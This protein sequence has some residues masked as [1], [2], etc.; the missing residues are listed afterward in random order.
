MLIWSHRTSGKK[1]S[2]LSTYCRMLNY[3]FYLISCRLKESV[4]IHSSRRIC[5]RFRLGRRR[6][7]RRR[8]CRFQYVTIQYIAVRL[9][10]VRPHSSPIPAA[11]PTGAHTAPAA[12]AT[13]AVEATAA[14]EATLVR[15]NSTDGFNAVRNSHR[16]VPQYKQ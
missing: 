7:I 10:M 8:R 6:R 11:L 9:Q 2:G 13:A 5:I 15:F 4:I 3:C 1:V 16:W 14:L 12:E